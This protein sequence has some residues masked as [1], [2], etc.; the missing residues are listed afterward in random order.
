MYPAGAIQDSVQTQARHGVNP[1]GG[2]RTLRDDSVR[3][4]VEEAAGLGCLF[5]LARPN[6]E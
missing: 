4:N 1:G 2:I 5:E 6:N 3:S